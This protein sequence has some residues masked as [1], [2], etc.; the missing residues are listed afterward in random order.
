MSEDRIGELEAE[1][2]ALPRTCLELSIQRN[3]IAAVARHASR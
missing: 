1:L 2:E 3:A